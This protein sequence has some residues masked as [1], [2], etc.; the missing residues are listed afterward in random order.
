M[1]F[2]TAFYLYLLPVG[3]VATVWG[4]IWIGEWREDRRRHLHPGE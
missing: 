4:A 2:A 1:T 3:I